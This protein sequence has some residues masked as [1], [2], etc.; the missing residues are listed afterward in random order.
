MRRTGKPPCNFGARCKRIADTSHTS[1]FSHPPPSSLRPCNFGARCNRQ[2]DPSH[3]A[4]FSHPSSSAD[5]PYKEELSFPNMGQV[6][7]TNNRTLCAIERAT[8]ALCVK[9]HNCIKVM[10]E[11]MDQVHLAV[12]Y[13]HRAAEMG[14]SINRQLVFTDYAP[15]ELVRFIPPP[16][17]LI[18]GYGAE[19]NEPHILSKDID[20]PES[21]HKFTQKFQDILQHTMQKYE[22]KPGRVKFQSRYGKSVFFR[23]SDEAKNQLLRAD[24]LVAHE[25]AQHKLYRTSFTTGVAVQADLHQLLAANSVP[26]VKES[27]NFKTIA[28]HEGK[29]HTIQ[30][31]MY[32]GDKGE[33]M[34]ESVSGKEHKL[35][36]DQASMDQ[37]K[38]DLRLALQ[39]AEI[40]Q[41]DHFLF[42]YVQELVNSVNVTYENGASVL[43]YTLPSNMFVYT[44]RHKQRKSYNYDN[45]FSIC[46]FPFFIF[47]FYFL[48]YFILFFFE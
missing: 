29:Y 38:L 20:V 46:F 11:T 15:E 44:I 32:I 23:L 43:S 24:T 18:I 19:I 21:E 42:P 12:D 13:L 41:E 1:R 37:S 25:T 6:V 39:F 2:G 31:N 17:S 8:G 48:F 30:V 45:I 35:C 10:G 33:I 9:V 7:G 22:N 47:Y 3:V 4:T 26:S 28:K 27:Y 16:P 5:L 40:I 14:Q 34:C 36:I